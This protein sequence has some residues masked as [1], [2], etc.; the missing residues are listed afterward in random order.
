M[1]LKKFSHTSNEPQ[2]TTTPISI[3]CFWL[4]GN[5]LTAFFPASWLHQNESNGTVLHTNI[6]NN[7]YRGWT[8]FY[9]HSNNSGSQQTKTQPHVLFVPV[10]KGIRQRTIVVCILDFLLTTLMPHL[11][12]HPADTSPTTAM[13]PIG[14]A[15]MGHGVLVESWGRLVCSP[16]KAVCV[17]AY[18][19]AK[20]MSRNCMNA[21][22]ARPAWWETM[23]SEKNRDSRNHTKKNSLQQPQNESQAQHSTGQQLH[24]REVAHRNFTWTDKKA[25]RMF[26]F[27]QTTKA[28]REH[29]ATDPTSKTPQRRI[30]AI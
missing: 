21:H 2:R 5:N 12:S 17:H 13:T 24:K 23:E 18:R 29:A 26:V 19:N 9:C 6:N 25:W 20:P 11:K 16:L 8:A 4:K 27:C 28:F 30:V 15:R 1:N 22:S 7:A 3:V 10:C 14:T